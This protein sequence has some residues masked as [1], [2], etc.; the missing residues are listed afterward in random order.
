MFDSKV[1]QLAIAVDT[2]T[3][4]DLEFGLL[5]RRC[6]F[7]FNHLNPGFI[8]NNFIAIL[9]RTYT[10][11][12]QSHRG[13]KL[14]GITT[15][16]GFRVAKHYTNFHTNLVN[17]D[18]QAVGG[19]NI[20]CQLAQRLG[21]QSSLQTY[22]MITHLALN[23]CTWCQCRHRVHNQYITGTG[24]NQ[25][26]GHLQRLFTGIGLGY[27]QIVHL[28]PQLLG[29]DR[30]QGVLRIDKG[31]GTTGLLRFGNYLQGQCCFTGGFRTIDLNNAPLWQ[32]TYTQCNIQAQG[33]G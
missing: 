16:G 27:H 6:Y 1:H 32:P 21:H 33:T 9:D 4:K 17:K 11:D 20:T 23:F 8:T 29:I 19:F 24:S 28:H 22:M 30:V 15:G 14:Q 7:V 31:A 12:I 2:L 26:I 18:N 5:K 25:H 3:V 10:T 13:V